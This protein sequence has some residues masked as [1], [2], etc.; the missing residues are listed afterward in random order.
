MVPFSGR[1]HEAIDL[2]ARAHQGQTRK[3]PDRHTPYVAHV[4]GVAYLLAEF[5]F[6]EDVVVAGLL[7]DVLEDQPGV[8]SD[9]E[10]FGDRVVALIRAVSEDKLDD[11]GHLRDWG[12]RKGEYIERMR[13][14]PPGAKAISCA[15]KIHNMQSILLALDR[16]TDIWDDLKATPAAQLRRFRRLREAL[17]EGWAHPILE[18]FD[19][20]YTRLERAAGTPPAEAGK[21]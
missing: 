11:Q 19:C 5:G 2:A 16:G 15:D 18:R 12:V 1:I 3:D 14:A 4:F 6:D 8:C 20:V 17:A 21:Q 7:H 10:R 13:S 9:L